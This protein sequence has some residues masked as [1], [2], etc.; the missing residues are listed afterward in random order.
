MAHNV[1]RLSTLLATIQRARPSMLFYAIILFLFFTAI[2][3]LRGNR[4]NLFI[5]EGTEK[6]GATLLVDGGNAGLLEI[7][8]AIIRG[9]IRLRLY[10]EMDANLSIHRHAYK[11]ADTTHPPTPLIQDWE[12]VKEAALSSTREAV[13]RFKRCSSSDMN[14]N[15]GLFIQSVVLSTLLHLF[16]QLP[17]TSTSIEDVV[18]I[19]DKTWRTE[20]SLNPHELRRMTKPSPNPSGVFALF[21]AMQRTILA[22]VCTLECRRDHIRFLRQAK[23]H[24]NDPTSPE[25][26]VI[27]L[28]EKTKES[29]PPIQ[30]VHGRLSIGPLPLDWTFNLDFFIPVDS[31]PHSGCIPGPD[32]VCEAW[33]HKIP[34]PGQSTCEGD[35]WFTRAS[36]IILSAIETEIRWA[37]LVVDR[38]ECDP[39][40]W[41]E[42]VLRRLRVG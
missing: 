25:P 14:M 32:G 40:E 38:D 7:T 10:R 6:S 42:W 29:H 23:T 9:Q 21:L 19:V 3:A 22:G 12:E 1:W 17:I 35:I 27:R 8:S 2:L 31:L 4:R 5:L 20:E 39:E 15:L 36:A 26:N 28:V 41:E 18:W 24:L 30:S 11:L 34:L 37:G 33:L 13:Q 16:F